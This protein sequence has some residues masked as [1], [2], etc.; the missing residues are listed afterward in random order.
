MG[1]C[2]ARTRDRRS[3]CPTKSV[4]EFFDPTGFLRNQKDR[5]IRV[6][7]A[8]KGRH[9]ALKT[10]LRQLILSPIQKQGSGTTESQNWTICQNSDVDCLKAEVYFLGCQG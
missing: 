8:A 10:S 2:A 4:H 3:D 6:R 1:C 7:K 5:L 9:F